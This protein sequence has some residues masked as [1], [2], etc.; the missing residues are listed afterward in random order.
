MIRAACALALVTLAAPALAD[1]VPADLAE[2]RLR[3]CL[4]AGASSASQSELAAKVIEVRAFCGAQIRRV[5]ANRTAAAAT[6]E[7]K[8]AAI[9]ALDTEIAQAVARFS[10]MTL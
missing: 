8:A 2:G 4:L 10:G 5:A 6:T 7:A 3:G 9:R 1:D